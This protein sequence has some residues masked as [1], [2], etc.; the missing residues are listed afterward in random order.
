ME[1][2][3]LV[4]DFVGLA[5]ALDLTFFAVEDAAEVEGR[6]AFLGAALAAAGLEFFGR[7]LL[8]LPEEDFAFLSSLLFIEE[9]PQS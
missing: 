9:T 8:A 7:E 3:A 2:L 6:A 5:A 1:G 4:L